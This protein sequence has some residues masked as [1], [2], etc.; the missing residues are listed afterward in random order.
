[1]LIDGVQI[2]NLAVLGPYL[3]WID[4]EKQFIDRANKTTGIINEGSTIMNQTPHLS[5]II[6][7]YIPTPEVFFYVL[8]LF[9][10][11]NFN[12]SLVV[13]FCI[14]ITFYFRF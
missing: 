8:I 14:N 5:D 1:M 12:I 7:V 9:I 2:T 4:K 3:Y 6:A 13:N 10:S 11:F